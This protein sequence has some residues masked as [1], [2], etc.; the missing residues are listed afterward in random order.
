MSYK[1]QRRRFGF[2][3]CQAEEH[4]LCGQVTVDVSY[5][6]W[7]DSPDAATAFR[8]AGLQDL[9]VQLCSTSEFASQVEC[10]AVGLQ[11][12]DVA[13]SAPKHDA[14][15]SQHTSAARAV[16]GTLRSF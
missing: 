13:A 7:L 14:Q 8:R 5:A 3:A 2:L 9:R 10:M 15:H 6:R 11:T 4:G 16:Q 12:G 1:R